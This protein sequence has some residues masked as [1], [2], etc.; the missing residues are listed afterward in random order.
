MTCC[1]ER[2]SPAAEPSL[3]RET[4]EDADLDRLRRTVLLLF[5][6]LLKLVRETD[7]SAISGFSG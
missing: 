3:A 7:E 2:C 5:L 6:V 1:G 4:D